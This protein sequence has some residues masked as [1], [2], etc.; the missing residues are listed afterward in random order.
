MLGLVHHP[1]N[2]AEQSTKL[3]GNETEGMKDA[4]RMQDEGWEYGFYQGDFRSSVKTHIWASIFPTSA[5]VPPEGQILIEKSIFQFFAD[6][7]TANQGLWEENDDSDQ[8]STINFSN[9]SPHA[10][11]SSILNSR[12]KAA[13]VVSVDWM[14]PPLVVQALEMLNSTSKLMKTPWNP[15][16]KS[17]SH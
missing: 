1:A 9:N 3:V 4:K 17:K 5:H 2:L 8:F 15:L 14:V 11:F 13:T 16:K 6:A 12:K 10:R 7:D